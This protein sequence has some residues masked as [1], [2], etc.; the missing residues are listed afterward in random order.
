MLLCSCS[1]LGVSGRF[2]DVAACGHG[3]TAPWLHIGW[4]RE[5]YF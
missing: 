2:G 5:Q 4:R 3:D 1:R